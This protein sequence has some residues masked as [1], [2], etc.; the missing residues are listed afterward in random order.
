MEKQKSNAEWKRMQRSSICYNGF[1]KG[2]A[3]LQTGQIWQ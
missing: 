1:E 2:A 3:G